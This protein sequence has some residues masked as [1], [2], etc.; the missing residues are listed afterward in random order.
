MT[1]A[2]TAHVPTA[3]TAAAPHVPAAAATTVTAA[4]PTAVLGYS[5]ERHGR[6]RNGCDDSEGPGKNSCVFHLGHGSTPSLR[7]CGCS[8]GINTVRD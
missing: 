2:T 3:A 5:R 8:R 6:Y 4:T 1:T 7:I